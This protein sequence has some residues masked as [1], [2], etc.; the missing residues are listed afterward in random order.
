[1]AVNEDDVAEEKSTSVRE[2]QGPRTI[3]S[4]IRNMRNLR[5]LL[6]HPRD[7]EGE[8]LLTHLNRIGCQ[9]TTRWPPLHEIPRDVDV[10]LIAV[11]PIVEENLEFSW[12][13]ENPPAAL[14]AIVDYENPLIVE[15]VLRLKASAVIG[16]PLRPFGILTNLL[17]SATNHKREQKLVGR[18]ERLTAKLR[19]FRDIDAAKAILIRTH[20]IS[21][22]QAYQIIRDQAMNRRTTVEDI[23]RAIITA[24]DLLNPPL[25]KS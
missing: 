7:S 12:D 18:I 20:G 17:L 10:V 9:V 2:R 6:M 24:S 3:S 25:T 5:I 8:E 4:L 21:E 22:G 11:R 15:R 13:A 16:L 14:M 1:M 23:A 19:A